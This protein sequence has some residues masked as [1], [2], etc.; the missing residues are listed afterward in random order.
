MTDELR[1]AN[2]GTPLSPEDTKCPACGAPV[3]ADSLFP[4]SEEFVDASYQNVDP[5]PEVVEAEVSEP[6]IIEADTITD[7]GYSVEEPYAAPP[8]ENNSMLRTCGI[9]CGV[10]FVV[11]LCCILSLAIFLWFAGDL[12][13]NIL[14]SLGI[15]VY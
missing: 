6:V 10:L 9:T 12:I 5:E 7:P 3:N 11:G 13:V 8:K 15:Y 1:C 2:C 14:R 4:E